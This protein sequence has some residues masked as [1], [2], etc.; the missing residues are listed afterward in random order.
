M[1]LSVILAPEKSCFLWAS[2]PLVP[3][4]LHYN[5]I[6]C[7]MSPG[8]LFPCP[9]PIAH[10]GKELRT[11]PIGQVAASEFYVNTENKMHNEEAKSVLLR[12]RGLMQHQRPA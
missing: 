8:V 7:S 5:I 4:H 2:H 11:F 1:P 9:L 6:N 10:L 12:K 3:Q